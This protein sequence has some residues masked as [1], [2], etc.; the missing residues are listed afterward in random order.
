MASRCVLE[1]AS[2]QLLDFD[3]LGLGFVFPRQR[4][5]EQSKRRAVGVAL[6]ENS[7]GDVVDRYSFPGFSFRLATM[8]VAVKSC[9]DAIAVE[10]FFQAAGS[11]KGKYFGRLA[12]D[13]G[14]N[15][16]VVKQRDNIRRS[17]T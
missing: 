5:V 15:R 10:R 2:A 1:S 4:N 3:G 11:E 16:R 13:R 7:Q 6:F 12:L 14:S 8:C 17:Q 9:D